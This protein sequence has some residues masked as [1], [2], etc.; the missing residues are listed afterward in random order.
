MFHI[1]QIY[2]F[3]QPESVAAKL[4]QQRFDFFMSLVQSLEAPIKILDVGGTMN[5]W[6][7]LGLPDEVFA[8]FEITLLNKNVRQLGADNAQFRSIVGDARN[9]SQFQDQAFDI[10]FSNS[11]IEHLGDFEGQKQMA[12]EIQRVG[13]RYFVQTPNYYFPVEPHFVFPIF[14]WLPIFVRVWLATHFHLGW[15]GKFSNSDTARAEVSSIR[16]LKRSEMLRL[17]PQGKMQ[18]EKIWGLTK[19]LIAY[20]G[21]ASGS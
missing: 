13:K 14:H 3:R 8:K 20:G 12:S 17:F 9:M 7:R 5:F 1:R 19:S 16:L 2:D 4:R 6:L 10:V 11:V 18:D 15:Y 21:W